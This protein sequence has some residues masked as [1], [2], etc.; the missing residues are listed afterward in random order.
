M[1]DD[2]GGRLIR[3]GLL[4]RGQLAEALGEAPPHEGALIRG[5]ASGGL[6]ED[7]LAGFFA[8]SGFGPLMEPAD[9][10]A[11]DPDAVA[12]LP[13]AM[14]TELLALPV[15]D[16][17]AGLIVAMAAPTDTHAVSEI[18]RA[19]R[20]EVLATVARIGDLL[21][22]LAHAYPGAA[23]PDEEGEHDSEPL[24]LE[25]VNVRKRGRRVAPEG[26][27]GST[28]GAERVEA[29]A[30]VGPRLV[31]QESDA[32]VPLVRTKPVSKKSEK[33]TADGLQQRVI[34]RSFEALSK[35]RD[36][37]VVPVGSRQASPVR[38]DWGTDRALR[39]GG[40][41]PSPKTPAKPANL[42]KPGAEPP[43]P[44]AMKH[45]PK[46]LE[47]DDTEID[48]DIVEEPPRSIIPREHAEWGS[49]DGPENKVDPG[50]IARVRDTRSRRAVTKMPE[51][52][53]TLVAIRAS[54]DRDE[55]VTLACQG[56]LTV[57]R[58]AVLL[59]LRKTVLKGWAG[60]GAGVSMG[61]V[62]NLWIPTSSPSMF[63]DVV[64]KKDAYNGAPGTA[65][66][67][68]LFRAALGSRGGSVS[69]QPVMVGTKLVAVFAADDMRFGEEGHQRI[70]TIARAISEA[71]ERIIMASKKRR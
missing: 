23:R 59:A 7:G 18:A 33:A 22:A 56:A 39:P 31:T 63:R 2:L 61:A 4:T 65:A 8:A 45:E 24:V 47:T 67:D 55:V 26:Y 43:Q 71:F 14:A 19:T 34:T 5:L 68:G 10:A 54:E 62:R 27:F 40:A 50:K 70:E 42:A 64:A 6:S 3:A 58:A 15:R 35:D 53:D 20:S 11:A 16:S 36:G 51:I 52:G 48:L 9:L 60:A 17:A 49:L 12:R 21:E 1:A 25:L 37:R 69:L 29:S 66:A 30:T 41:T 32:F 28:K 46:G 57:S 44:A 13:A 38:R